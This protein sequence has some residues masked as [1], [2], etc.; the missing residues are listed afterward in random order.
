MQTD[1]EK[2]NTAFKA[3]CMY[4]LYEKNNATQLKAAFSALTQERHHE[5]HTKEKFGG[6]ED[7]SF[8][9]CKNQICIAAKKILLEESEM[10]VVVNPLTSSL[11]ERYNI[12][13]NM[14]PKEVIIFL[15]EKGLIQPTDKEQEGIMLKL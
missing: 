15:E 7:S 13:V 8:M 4:L 6:K 14:T 10:K 1:E 11:L 5:F 12:K 9:D 2:L 3:G